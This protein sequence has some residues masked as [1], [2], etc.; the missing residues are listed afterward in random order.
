MRFMQVATCKLS[1]QILTGRTMVGTRIEKRRN[2]FETRGYF[3]VQVFCSSWAFIH[4][5][6]SK[7]SRRTGRC[8]AVTPSVFVLTGAILLEVLL[9]SQIVL[10]AGQ[11]YPQ[12]P[13]PKELELSRQLVALQQEKDFRENRSLTQIRDLESQVHK[14]AGCSRLLRCRWRALTHLPH[15]YRGSQVAGSRP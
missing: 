6:S 7:S 14:Y 3:V 1:R 5:N 2:R 8:G 10:H 15:N 12:V 9:T 11:E 13:T 4:A